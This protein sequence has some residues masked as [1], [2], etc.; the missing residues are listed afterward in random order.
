MQITKQNINSS[1][2]EMG[3]LL[4]G[5]KIFLRLIEEMDLS[6][7][8]EWRNAPENWRYFFNKRPLSRGHQCEW[9]EK[10]SKDAS[11]LFFIICSLDGQPLGTIGLSKIDFCSQSAEI[12]NVLLAQN[13]DRH[14]GLAKEALNLIVQHAFYLLNLNRLYLEVFEENTDAIGLYTRL[15]FQKEGVLRE[16]QYSGSKFRNTIIMGL[17]RNEYKVS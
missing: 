2:N 13:K 9:Y 14:C 12:G 7:L 17:L 8:V 15:G 10:L 16:S 5:E 1:L 11:Q 4:R 6:L 3:H